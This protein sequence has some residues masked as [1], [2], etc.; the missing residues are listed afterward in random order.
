[1]LQQITE[2]VTKEPIRT[3]RVHRLFRS[4]ARFIYANLCA[5]TCG[6][7]F[8]RDEKPGNKKNPTTHEKITLRVGYAHQVHALYQRVELFP[9]QRRRRRHRLHRH[10]RIETLDSRL[11]RVH[12]LKIPDAVAC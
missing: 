6:T 1:M 5:Q 10:E 7:L 12:A 8:T 4:S 2:D 11:G 9:L 3:S